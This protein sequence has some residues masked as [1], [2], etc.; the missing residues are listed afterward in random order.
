MAPD[1]D[2]PDVARLVSSS[3]YASA[4]RDCGVSVSG[5]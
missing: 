4:P 3:S 5:R 2:A 1:D